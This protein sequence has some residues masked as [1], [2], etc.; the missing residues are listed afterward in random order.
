MSAPQR[1]PF[2]KG[3]PAARTTK[4]RLAVNQRIQQSMLLRKRVAKYETTR[5]VED[6]RRDVCAAC[7]FDAETIGEFR[8]VDL[9]ITPKRTKSLLDENNIGG[10]DAGSDS[11]TD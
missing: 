4:S 7:T 3:T 2:K 6:I 8:A 11:D 9:R 10:D 1:W 5:S